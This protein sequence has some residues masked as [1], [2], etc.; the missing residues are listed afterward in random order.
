MAVHRGE[1]TQFRFQ[2]PDG[3]TGK[4]VRILARVKNVQLEVI[5]RPNE[6]AAI[7]G[8][9]SSMAAKSCSTFTGCCAGVEI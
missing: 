2:D 3:F 1:D 4:T 8:G 9:C 5:A 6:G 7:N